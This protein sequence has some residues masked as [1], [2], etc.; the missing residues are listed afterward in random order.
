MKRLA[1]VAG[2]IMLLAPTIYGSQSPQATQNGTPV[3]ATETTKDNKA[4]QPETNKNL[5]MTPSKRVAHFVAG[6]GCVLA[7]VLVGLGLFSAFSPLNKH[8]TDDYAEGWKQN[9]ARGVFLTTGA[10]T[11]YGTYSLFIRNMKQFFSKAFGDAPAA[12]AAAAV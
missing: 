7:T 9:L 2:A 11:A 12:H 6:T 3:V 1:A 8:V 5:L 10:A 4:I